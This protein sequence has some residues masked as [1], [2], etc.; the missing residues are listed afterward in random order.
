MTKIFITLLVSAVTFAA[1]GADSAFICIIAS[2]R[3]NY[4]VGDVPTI[5][6][7]ITNRS[8]KEVILVGSLDGS[9]DGWRFPKCRLEILD[10]VGK[11]VTA[12]MARCGHMNVLRTADFVAVAAGG[13]FNP[14]GGGFFAPYQFH[15]FPVTTPGDYTLRFYY[16]TSDRV[17]DY[18]GD[19]RMMGR[20]NATPEIQRLFKRVPKLELKSNELKL[21]FTPKAK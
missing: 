18:F 4:A 3:T 13:T 2:D 20:T 17:Q 15:Q 8:A 12:P 19:E 5:T 6:V 14:Y 7:S 10:A 16:S 9:N 1:V 21:K 11:P